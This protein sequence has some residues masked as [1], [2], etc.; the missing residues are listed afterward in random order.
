MPVMGWLYCF[1]SLKS[2]FVL[3]ENFD[4]QRELECL[5]W[6]KREAFQKPLSA[7]KT[8]IPGVEMSRINVNQV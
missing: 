8:T 5:G 4:L 6:L 2:S 1:G 3:Q 7:L